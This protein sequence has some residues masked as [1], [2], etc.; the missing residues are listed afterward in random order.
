MDNATITL[1]A[2]PEIRTH[3]RIGW[4][5]FARRNLMGL[6]GVAILLFLILTAI[7]GPYL[8]PAS[9]TSIEFDAFL[10]PSAAHPFGT[11]LL[12]RD[13]FSRV[14]YGARISLGIGFAAVAIG[15]LGGSLV[16]VIA[17]YFGGW[18]DY[19][20]QRLIEV[21][22]AFPAL[23]LLIILA[24]VFG[25]SVRNVILILGI[26]A[27]PIMARVVR[28]IVL[29]ER[30]QPYVEAARSLGATNGRVLLVHVFPS[31]LPLAGILS[32][33]SLGSLILAEAGLSFL[34]LGVP[35]PTPSWGADLG[36]PARTYFQQAPWLAIFPGL[37]VSITILGANMLAE[38]VRDIIDPF[39]SGMNAGK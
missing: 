36:G 14:I 26:Y 16:G 38:A 7:I 37:A 23:V 30:E 6:T 31:V 20:I 32:A 34:G 8:V 28:S 15:S 22:M 39:S 29:S 18:V 27:I 5:T 11:D 4:R 3:H 1:G 35:A 21:V 19:V 2:T 12:G 9:P 25:A 33:L 13:V 10:R 17:A 24:A